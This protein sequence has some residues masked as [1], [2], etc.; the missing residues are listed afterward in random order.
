MYIDN[1][2]NALTITYNPTEQKNQLIVNDIMPIKL[3][4]TI[5]LDEFPII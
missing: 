4:I 1:V 3:F 2:S 5:V